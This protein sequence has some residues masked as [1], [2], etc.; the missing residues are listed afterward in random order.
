MTT[1]SSTPRR[2]VAQTEIQEVA[3]A[4]EEAKEAADKAGFGKS[5]DEDHRRSLAQREGRGLTSLAFKLEGLESAVHATKVQEQLNAEPGVEAVVVYANAMAWISAH[6]DID[7]AALQAI[8][9][10]NGLSSWLTHSS[11]R[12]R[13]A[14]LEINESRTRVRH[15][16]SY[17]RARR[18][19]LAREMRRY[20][21][22]EP[23]TEVLHT[24]RELIT[25]S[26]LLVAVL[27]GLPVIALQLMEQWQ[28]TYWQWVCLALSTPVALWSAWPFHR[29]FLVG[30]RRRMSALDGASSLA[31]TISYLYS[32]GRLV[33]TE[34]GAAGWTNEQ[35]L[36]PGS[37]SG[38]EVAGSIFFDVACGATI[39]LLFGRLL[40]RITV[41]R[42]RSMLRVLT[43][44]SDMEVEVF[45]KS[46]K[47]LAVKKLIPVAE[48]RTGDDILIPEGGLVPSDGE[49]ISGKSKVDIGPAGGL[50]HI[51]TVSVG[52]VLYA[53]A[54]N[55][56][57]P[58]KMRV[59]ETGSS[60]RLA[61]MH[62][63]VV[64]T[65]RDENRLAQLTNRTAGA[66]VPWAV[67][68]AVLDFALWFGFTQS[69]DAAVAT[70]ISVLA[71]VAPVALALSAPLP[72]RLGLWRAAT[73]GALLRDT[74]T[75][76]S[77]AGVDSIIF[78][79]VGTL[80]TGPMHVIGVTAAP[81]ENPDL[82]LRVAGALSLESDHPV[83][84][85]IVRA[86]REARDSNAGGDSVPHWIE[87]GEIRITQDGAFEG[88]IMLPVDGETRR[89]P[90][91][92]WR[93]RDLGEIQNP[94]LGAAAVSGGS[95]VVVSWKGRDRGVITLDDSFKSDAADAIERLESMD[96][97]TYML[98][99][100]TYPVARRVARSL[101]ISTV[102]AGISPSRKEAT[103]RGVHAQG[104]RVAMVGN[105]DVIGALKVA[106]A[107]ILMG[108]GDR[109]DSDIA[110]AAD[111]VLLRDD[112][113][114]IPE[115]I[116][117]V[118]HVLATAKWNAIF[119]WAYT[120]AAMAAALIGVLN[121]LVATVMMLAS[122]AFVEGRSARILNKT[123]ATA[124]TIRA[125]ALDN[126]A[127]YRRQ[128][129]ELRTR[130]RLLKQ[131]KR[132]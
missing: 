12:R 4:I 40:S 121:P 19:A 24:A 13:S 30:L 52:D 69:L 64:G 126:W 8:F 96:L 38:P 39:L 115:I 59:H 120:I 34:A 54:R 86:D 5:D 127:E 66:L 74:A 20:R 97:E 1:S 101:G 130:R 77:L 129:R 9:H 93:P 92:L 112:V 57:R 94:R 106:D 6:D 55:L 28:F 46:K 3:Q 83:S 107:G 53:G 32:V 10:A 132:T 110:A 124:F 17:R 108:A 68:V 48:I 73:K 98:S 114:A 84:R 81:G 125:N 35:I 42:S 103:V 128:R 100:D 95:P 51:R 45:R 47:A 21:E 87:T 80:T 90:A 41:L 56:G 113:M 89:V 122:S 61:A 27:F 58:L 16:S 102:L 99:R 26:R 82:L 7:P 29:A 119:S 33:F 36:L 50:H 11:L 118:R 25:K 88:Y 71:A 31:I 67:L 123:Y 79:R 14:R 2:D 116:N 49:I 43:I 78:N 91:R 109:I 15:H 62:R 104:A 18:Q 22:T 44:P 63:W 75:I 131:P 85:A 117:L 60:T 23:S 105:K 76:Y 72:L 37:W 111:I 65:A 70:A